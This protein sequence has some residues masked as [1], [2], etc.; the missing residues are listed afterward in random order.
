MHCKHFRGLLAS[1]GSLEQ[2]STELDRT[3]EQVT[4]P[5]THHAIHPSS[6]L[7]LLLLSMSLV[8]ITQ[9]LP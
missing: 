4:R 7:F 3:Y 2:A 1:E 5:L 9:M 8:H 6:T